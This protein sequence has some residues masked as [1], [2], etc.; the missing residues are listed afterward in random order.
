MSSV[1]GLL[2]LMSGR[3]PGFGYHQT[4]YIALSALQYNEAMYP[5]WVGP[6]L[7]IEVA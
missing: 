6:Q 4:A 5:K 3:L 7:A 1:S 2:C